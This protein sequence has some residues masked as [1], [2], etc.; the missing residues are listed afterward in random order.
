MAVTQVGL[1]S[2]R[3][4]KRAVVGQKRERGSATIHCREMVAR[5]AKDQL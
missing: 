3:A 2:A 1:G 4:Q 5:S